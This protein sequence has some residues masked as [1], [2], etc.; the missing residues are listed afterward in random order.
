MRKPEPKEIKKH[1]KLPYSFIT[2]PEEDAGK[3]YYVCRVAELPGCISY[4]T[5]PKEAQE[6]IKSAMYDWIET[7]LLDGFEVPRPLVE[8]ETR[9]TLRVPGSVEAK[10]KLEA[11]RQNKSLNQFIVDKLRYA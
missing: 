5:T 10:I 4:G 2:T 8:K 1:L 11:K 6:K 7:S 9:I 3:T